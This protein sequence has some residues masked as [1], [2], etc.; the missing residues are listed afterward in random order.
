[1]NPYGD[2]ETERKIAELAT[3]YAQAMGGGY[4]RAV[5]ALRSIVYEPAK[6]PYIEALNTLGVKPCPWTKLSNAWG[7]LVATV[8][9]TPPFRWI[10]N[11]LWWLSQ[12]M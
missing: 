5:D 4:D 2:T 3:V 11:L 1:M 7:D 10:D 9:Q 6:P 12:R 8:L